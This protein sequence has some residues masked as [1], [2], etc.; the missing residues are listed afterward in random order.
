MVMGTFTRSF[1]VGLVEISQT[2]EANVASEE[3]PQEPRR[4]QHP[5]GAAFQSGPK[6]LGAC[7]PG[8][9]L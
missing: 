8:L 7:C 3:G 9:S 6:A 2:L 4:Y 1:R 5:R